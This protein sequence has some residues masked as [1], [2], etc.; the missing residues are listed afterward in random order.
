MKKIEMA[1]GSFYKPITDTGGFAYHIL[2]DDFEYFYADCFCDTTS[3]RMEMRAF[4]EGLK[5]IYN[6]YGLDASVVV[7]TKLQSQIK[8]LKRKDF[9]GAN[10]DLYDSVFN[11]PTQI[12]EEI[13][14]ESPTSEIYALVNKLTLIEES[15]TPFKKDKPI[16]P[17]S[18]ALF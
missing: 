12:V 16:E 5:F 4:I 8:A 9:Q 18:V 7:Y 1:I 6:K 11:L 10:K 17:N 2:A 13:I 3:Q 15:K 14:H